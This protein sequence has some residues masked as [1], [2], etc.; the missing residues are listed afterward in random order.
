M[1]QKSKRKLDNFSNVSAAIV[2]AVDRYVRTRVDRDKIIPNICG[3]RTLFLCL[4]QTDRRTGKNMG[5]G[6]GG[7][8][9]SSALGFSI[10]MASALFQNSLLSFT[11]SCRRRSKS[12]HEFLKN[13]SCRRMLYF[14]YR[15]FE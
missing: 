8:A 7:A 14:K 10:W 12:S 2:I 3:M 15:D 6:G 1:R 9:P 11:M 4:N 5:V 13:G